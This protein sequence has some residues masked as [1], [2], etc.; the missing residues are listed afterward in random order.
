MNKKTLALIL[1]SAFILT[2]PGVNFTKAQVYDI[3]PPTCV[4]A[5]GIPCPDDWKTN[6]TSEPQQ[7]TTPSDINSAKQ[8]LDNLVKNINNIMNS[9]KTGAKNSL[10]YLHNIFDKIFSSIGK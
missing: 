2:V 6:Q 4:P 3:P 10:D 8:A 7:P 9:I 5:P 1:L